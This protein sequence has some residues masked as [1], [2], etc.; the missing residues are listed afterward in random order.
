[1]SNNDSEKRWL[2][3]EEYEKF[4]NGNTPNRSAQQAMR[5]SHDAVDG[6]GLPVVVLMKKGEPVAWYDDENHWGYVKERKAEQALTRAQVNGLIDLIGNTRQLPLV[7]SVYLEKGA[8]KAQVGWM[9]QRRGGLV[10]TSE[11]LYEW[12]GEEL[13]WKVL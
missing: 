4:V 9:Q 1:M 6:R 11:S 12:I 2:T 3:D 8:V 10:M 7:R 13:K 5:V